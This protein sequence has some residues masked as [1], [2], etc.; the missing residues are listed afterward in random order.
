M[1]TY[2]RK[3]IYIL[4]PKKGQNGF[5]AG[6]DAS[7]IEVVGG[8]ANAENRREA[9]ERELN[10]GLTWNERLQACKSS[11]EIQAFRNDAWQVDRAWM[12]FKSYDSWNVS[13]RVNALLG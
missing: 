2:A 9:F 4:V 8:R 11:S 13:D 10:G 5:V 7:K 6:I 3:Q 12:E 1:K